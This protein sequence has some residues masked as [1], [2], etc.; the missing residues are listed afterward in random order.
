MKKEVFIE[1][2]FIKTKVWPAVPTGSDVLSNPN[3]S[4]YFSLGLNERA[5]S[6]ITLINKDFRS[7]DYRGSA[8]RNLEKHHK[9]PLFFAAKTKQTTTTTQPGFMDF[10][11]LWM[12]R[13][14]QPGSAC[15]GLCCDPSSPSPFPLQTWMS[16]RCWTGA[17]SRA[18]PTPRAPSSASAGRDFGCTPTGAP[19]SVRNLP[20]LQHCLFPLCKALCT[21]PAWVLTK[22]PHPFCEDSAIAKFTLYFVSGFF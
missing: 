12:S 18:V 11:A 15:A 10:Y 3:S 22:Y 21:S 13:A 2:V 14:G 16:V 7:R 8:C 1:Q 9:I 19:A 20:S 17:A 4:L 5:M 6:Q